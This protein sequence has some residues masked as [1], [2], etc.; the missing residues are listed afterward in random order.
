MAEHIS[1]QFDADLEAV[2][3]RVLHMGGVVEEQIIKAIDGLASGNLAAIV[4]M[5]SGVKPVFQLLVYPATD[6][7]LGQASHRENAQGYLL[8]ADSMKWFIGHYLSGSHV[9]PTDPRLSPLFAADHV[10]ATTPPAMVI[11]AEFDPL[12][13]EGDAYARGLAAAGVKVQHVQ[14]HGH[15][16]T[17]I[18]MVD[19]IISGVRHREQMAAALRGFFA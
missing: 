3:T 12:R 11:T 5:H 13:D 4:S 2:R 15:M 18:T 10:V 7:R 14:A 9:E 19:V 6:M 8:T 17:S 16:H 1:K